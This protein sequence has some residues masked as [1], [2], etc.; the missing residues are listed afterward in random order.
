M[1][2]GGR[3]YRDGVLEDVVAVVLGEHFKVVLVIFG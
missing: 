2:V 1:V 3:P